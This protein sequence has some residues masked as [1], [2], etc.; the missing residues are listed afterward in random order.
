M[1]SAGESF[2]FLSKDQAISF[3]NAKSWTGDD[4]SA[5]FQQSFAES[6]SEIIQPFDL[7]GNGTLILTDELDY[8]TDDHVYNLDVTVF[9][10]FGQS[11]SKIFTV[12]LINEV[13]DLDG[14]E[15]E[16]HYDLDDDN[17]GFSDDK[18]IELGFDHRNIYSRPELALVQT[19]TPNRSSDGKYILRG[20]LLADGGVQLSDL[21]F[22]VTGDGF[23]YNQTLNVD[24]NITEGSEFTLSLDSLNPGE[25]YTFR[26]YVTNV[27]GHNSGALRWWFGAEELETGWKSNWFGVFYLNQMAGLITQILV[28]CLYL[29]TAMVVYGSG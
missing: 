4:T 15:I 17:D 3:Y 7:E 14:D 5:F 1:I 26:A 8:E 28:G 16:D 22:E 25:T 24:S 23:A 20:K 11:Y 27:V 10:Q 6:D 9:D 21:G 19:L 12:N 13:E 18:E 2:F 29:R